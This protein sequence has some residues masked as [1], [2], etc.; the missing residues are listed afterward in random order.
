[1]PLPS[2]LSSIFQSQGCCPVLASKDTP[3]SELKGLRGDKGPTAVAAAQGMGCVRRGAE[4]PRRGK[5]RQPKDQE[6]GPETGSG[7]NLDEI[8]EISY[9][10][11]NPTCQIVK[12]PVGKLSYRS[13][14]YYTLLDTA[15]SNLHRIMSCVSGTSATLCTVPRSVPGARPLT[16]RLFFFPVCLQGLLHEADRRTDSRDF[17]THAG[18]RLRRL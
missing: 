10:A 14:L 3:L 13:H 2:H 16:G 6:I 11:T 4:S 1:M 18:R 9:W 8:D 15:L 5:R 12:S 17:P 7:D